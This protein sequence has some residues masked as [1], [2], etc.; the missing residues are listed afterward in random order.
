[1]GSIPSA[2]C[3]SFKLK[4]LGKK[5]KKK[6]QNKKKQK[7]KKK[8]QKHRKKNKNKKKDKIGKNEKRKIL[9]SLPQQVFTNLNGKDKTKKQ[10][11]KGGKENE[12]K[13]NSSRPPQI[14]TLSLSRL[15]S[16]FLSLSLPSFVAPSSD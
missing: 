13:E 9:S 16:P 15:L 5:E 14:E 6:G 10:Q 2:F 12:S 8:N 11:K 1:L 3:N 4:H 7:K